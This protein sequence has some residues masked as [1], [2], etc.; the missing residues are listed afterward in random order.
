[1]NGTSSTHSTPHLAPI[2]ASLVAPNSRHLGP[3]AWSLLTHLTLLAAVLIWLKWDSNTARIQ[4]EAGLAGSPGKRSGTVMVEVSSPAQKRATEPVTPRKIPVPRVAEKIPA[5]L[6][7]ELPTRLKSETRTTAAPVTDP[8]TRSELSKNPGSALSDS[9]P[10]EDGQN[11]IG[12][13]PTQT[14]IG[15][16]DRTNPL[17]AHLKTI[18]DAIQKNLRRPGFALSNGSKAT[19]LRMKIAPSGEL[20]NAEIHVSSGDP[21]L[22]QIALLAVKRAAPFQP[23]SRELTITIPAI[24]KG[25]TFR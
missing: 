17:G 15:N 12:T 11:G 14:T 2:A 1:M 13:T 20:L 6:P 9:A 8:A 5:H 7:S 21:R 18:R 3:F 24:F 10:G 22:D 19:S 23:Y 16:S 25:D 4:G